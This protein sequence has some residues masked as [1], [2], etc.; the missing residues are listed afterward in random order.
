MKAILEFDLDDFDDTE[1]FAI[2]SKAKDYQICLLEFREY[3]RYH[4][5]HSNLSSEIIDE[6]ES[7]KEKLFELMDERHLFFWKEFLW[8]KKNLWNI[9]NKFITYF[10]SSSFFSLEI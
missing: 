7:I 1:N 4:Y 10:L 5:K 8:M 2:C 3:L 6:I 9:K